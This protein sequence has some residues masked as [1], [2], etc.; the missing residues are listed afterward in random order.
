M[1]HTIHN[2]AL[3]NQTGA[4]YLASNQPDQALKCFQTALEFVTHADDLSMND[5]TSSHSS[6]QSLTTAR[7]EENE[8]DYIYT[9]PFFFNPA[10]SMT[11]EE[12]AP[13][14]AV[15][16][17]NLALSYH[18]RAKAVGDSN[19]RVAMKFYDKCLSFLRHHS[20][21]DCSNVIIAALHNQARIHEQLCDFLLAGLKYKMLSDF[22]ERDEIRID[23]LGTEDLRAICLNIYFFQFPT[24]A[25]VA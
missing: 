6:R 20:N 14:G 25:P 24:C 3:L 7:S 13:F 11:E 21:F 15:I 2:A 23:T 22:L 19:L 4:A 10:A 5:I 8:D 9:K 16:L 17:F 1:N 12:I 18:E